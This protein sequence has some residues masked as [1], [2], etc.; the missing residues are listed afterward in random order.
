MMCPICG[1]KQETP[2]SSTHL[3]HFFRCTSCGGHFTNEFPEIQYPEAYFTEESSTLGKILKRILE[4]FLWL[5]RRTILRALPRAGKTILDYGCGNGKLITYM[6]RHG[7]VV[8]GYDPSPSAV[9][10]ARAQ[11]L[12]VFDHVPDKQ[13]DLIMFWHSLEHTDT[14]LDDVKKLLPHLAPNGRLLIAVPNGDGIEAHIAHGTWFCYDWPFH[15]VHFT[16]KS[17]TRM[18][19][20]AGFRVCSI[21]MVN[22]EYTL[23]S[24]A[25]TFLNLILPKNVFYSVVANR[26]QDGGRWKVLTLSLLSLTLLLIFSPLLLIFFLLELV[27][28][29]TAAMIVV[30]E[31]KYI[32]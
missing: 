6:K 19:D 3:P 17:L 10:L 25:Q 24:I 22:L 21:Y 20:T 26:R 5:R 2:A 7:I 1:K 13:Y 29:R 28:G 14:P 8:D 32:V 31:R 27:L 11:G 15:R 23:S 9:T 12:P 18:L 30:A 4:L 16:P